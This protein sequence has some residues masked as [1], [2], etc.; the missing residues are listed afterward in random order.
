LPIVTTI[1]SPLLT[2]AAAINEPGLMPGLIRANI[3]LV[4]RRTENWYLRRSNAVICV[5]EGVRAE[6]AAHYEQPANDDLVIPN[7]V[8][9]D[10]FTPP[11]KGARRDLLYVGRLGYRK[12]LLRLLEA[13]AQ[14]S[15][16][17]PD[18]RLALVGD[19]PLE[20]L[21]RRR[22]A[23]LGIMGKVEFCG[24]LARAAV[25]RHLQKAAVVVNPADYE[26]GPVTILEAMACCAPVVSTRTGLMAEIGID[27]RNVLLCKRCPN[28][29]ARAVAVC[30]D[31]PDASARRA[32]AGRHLL[33]RD[34]GWDSVVDRLEALYQRHAA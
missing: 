20:P 9:L 10:Y 13:F 14:L 12:G 15:E 18:L 16:S 3:R 25:R 26:S 8:D 34:Y 11:I 31:D 33:E 24:F 32:V 28:D 6:I 2:D 19:G 29:L 1:H 22:C 30:L 4:S 5:S 17:R 27:G 7:A 21:L 23:A